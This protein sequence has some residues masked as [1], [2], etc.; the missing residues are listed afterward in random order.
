MSKLHDGTDCLQEV[1][2]G[3]AL[4]APKAVGSLQSVD[5][6]GRW[7][8]GS[9]LR[10]PQRLTRAFAL[11]AVWCVETIFLAKGCAGLLSGR[12]LAGRQS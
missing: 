6:S 11:I 10:R 5:R 2:E 12:L 8:Q 3:T 4:H 9:T 1:V 7:C